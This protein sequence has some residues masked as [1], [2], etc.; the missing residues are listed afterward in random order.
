MSGF[1]IGQTEVTQALWEAVMGNNPSHFKGNN[2]PVESVSRDDC[3]TFLSKLNSITGKNFR[4][5]TEAEWEFAARGGNNSNHTQYS[6]SGNINDIAWYKGNSGNK[7]HSVAQLKANELGIYDMC[8][9]VWEWCSDWYGDY[10]NIAQTNPTGA[11]NGTYRVFRGGDWK[12]DARYCRSSYRTG[13][14]PDTHY[15]GLGFR[16]CLSE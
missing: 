6:G 9:N 1:S 4:R 8:G 15:E 13:N 5:P 16:L 14:S 7:T 12:S 10:S 11:V 2:L 3:K